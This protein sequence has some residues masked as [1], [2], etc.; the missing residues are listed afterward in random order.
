MIKKEPFDS[1]TQLHYTHFFEK[2][3][4][5]VESDRNIFFRK[6]NIDLVIKCD[7]QNR[8]QLKNTVFKHFLDF[9]AIELK[10]VNDG[11]TLQD[12]NRIM[13]RVWGLG[14]VKLTKKE[15]KT[16]SPER[17]SFWQTPTLPEPFKRTLTIVCVERPNKILDD[18]AQ[19]LRFVKT[20]RAGVY[21]CDAVL[22]RWIIHPDELD[23][24]PENYP[25]LALARGKKLQQFLQFCIKEGKVDYL[26]LVLDIGLLTNPELIWNKIK[27]IKN[28]PQ[29]ISENT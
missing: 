11:L 2:L 17:K 8:Q 16:F 5:L 1:T 19:K 29:A 28:M 27:E 21:Y 13:M 15:E 10:G 23:L 20:D 9:N 22:Q 4:F 7:E 3:G 6:R 14:S 24:I 26:Q 12:Y 18:L 25:L